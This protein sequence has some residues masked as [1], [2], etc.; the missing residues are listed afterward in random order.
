MGYPV[1]SVACAV[2]RGSP[3]F[4]FR[5]TRNGDDLASSPRVLVR[6]YDKYSSVEISNVE[7]EDRGNYS[8]SASNAAGS[9]I[10]VASLD[11][12][13]ESPRESFYATH[14]ACR[15]SQIRGGAQQYFR[16]IRLQGVTALQS[17]RLPRASRRVVLAGA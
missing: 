16:G 6:S 3:P 2:V 14:V 13:R 17:D 5:W 8:C 12:K 4:R 11:V 10:F 7:A 1:A 9:D 15:T